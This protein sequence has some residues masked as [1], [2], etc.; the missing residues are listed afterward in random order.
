[1]NSGNCIFNLKQNA[2]AVAKLKAG[3]DYHYLLVEPTLCYAAHKLPIES[4]VLGR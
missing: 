3:L 1:M 2:S 4:I